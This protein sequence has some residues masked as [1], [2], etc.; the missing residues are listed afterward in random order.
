MIYFQHVTT[1]PFHSHATAFTIFLRAKLSIKKVLG[2]A[3]SMYELRNS[4]SLRCLKEDSAYIEME[5]VNNVLME[6]M[7]A[8]IHLFGVSHC[9]YGYLVRNIY[10]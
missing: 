3:V 10:I 6:D 9:R 5:H 8:M 1:L 7:E 4:L 2:G